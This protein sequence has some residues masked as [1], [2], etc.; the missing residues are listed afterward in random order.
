MPEAL[1][2]GIAIRSM[3][4]SSASRRNLSPDAWLTKTITRVVVK[5]TSN[6]ADMAYSRDFPSSLSRWLDAIYVIRN[7]ESEEGKLMH[8][9]F[10]QTIFSIYV[11]CFAS[12]TATP[13]LN[14]S[15]KMRGFHSF[16][17]HGPPQLTCHSWRVELRARQ[18]SSSLHLSL[19]HMT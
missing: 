18:D 6:F 3:A 5:N 13:D 7:C 9:V 1:E 2:R 16:I 12:L 17:Q 11:T 10:M 15:F 19:L 14:K 4:Y 8:S